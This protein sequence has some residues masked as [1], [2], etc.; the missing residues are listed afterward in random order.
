MNLFLAERI[1]EERIC[2]FGNNTRENERKEG[3]IVV[4]DKKKR[5]K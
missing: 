1:G 2:S 4:K 5:E 3:E